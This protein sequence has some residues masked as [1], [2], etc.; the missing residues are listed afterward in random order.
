[1]DFAGEEREVER[2]ISAG[3][4]G[5]NVNWGSLCGERYGGSSETRNR[6]AM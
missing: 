1:M 6:T 3:A 2:E 4:A 5:G